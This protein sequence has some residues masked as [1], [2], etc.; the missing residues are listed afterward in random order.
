MHPSLWGAAAHMTVAHL[1][2]CSDS[3]CA[4]RS[5]H[6]S[7]PRNSALTESIFSK[8]PGP[9][10]Q[11]VSAKATIRFW[12]SRSTP[13]LLPPMSPIVI[14][15]RGVGVRRPACRSQAWTAPSAGPS[16]PAT[17][18]MDFPLSRISRTVSAVNAF[19]KAP[20]LALGHGTLLRDARASSSVHKTLGGRTR[21]SQQRAQTLEWCLP[22]E[23]VSRASMQLSGDLVEAH[24]IESGE[25]RAF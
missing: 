17:T 18:T 9:S 25:V 22:T 19:V 20:P 23:R 14:I 2:S 21:S 8:P 7:S 16:S 24:L 5:G 1:D 15:G 10:S 13:H 3:R 11:T 12:R 4:G 6:R